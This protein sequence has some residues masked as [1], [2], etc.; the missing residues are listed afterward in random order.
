[1]VP[2]VDG[3][4]HPN[5]ATVKVVGLEWTATINVN[6]PIVAES[7]DGTQQDPREA[8]L[9]STRGL[10]PTVL[11]KVAMGVVI[12]VHLQ[13]QIKKALLTYFNQLGKK[14]GK[15]GLKANNSNKKQNL[16]LF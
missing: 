3:Y 7:H 9:V 10:Q 5:L 15:T 6:W 2:G 11:A 14:H 1:M 13:K 12:H 4:L 16:G 8:R